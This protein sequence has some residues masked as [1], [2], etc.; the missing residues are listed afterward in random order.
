MIVPVNHVYMTSINYWSG[1]GS[2]DSFFNNLTLVAI[3]A[4]LKINSSRI[5]M[6]YI[7][8]SESLFRDGQKDGFDLY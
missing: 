2:V 5:Q 8:I 4:G 3:K 7:P 1:K 6:F